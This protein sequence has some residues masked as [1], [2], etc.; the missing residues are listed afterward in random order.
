MLAAQDAARAA[1]LNRNDWYRLQRA[2]VH[3]AA[4]LDPTGVGFAYGGIYPGALHAKGQLHEKHKECR[5]QID[6][7][8][9]DFQ[10][11]R[12]KMLDAIRDLT[13]VGKLK[14]FLIER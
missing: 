5:R 13:K 6:D 8:A 7:L 10:V 2:L 14:S 1:C 3:E 11:E 4:L 12:E 9:V